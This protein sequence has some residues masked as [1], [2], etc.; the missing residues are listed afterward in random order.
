MAH[1][2]D[3]AVLSRVACSAAFAPSAVGIDRLIRSKG[4]E[5]DRLMSGSWEVSG[6]VGAVMI[7]ATRTTRTIKEKDVCSII[8]TLTGRVRIPSIVGPNV[9]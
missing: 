4:S 7:R 1:V 8:M 5:F 3:A 6:Q 9:D 2:V